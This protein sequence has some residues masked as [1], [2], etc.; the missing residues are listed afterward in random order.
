MY[1]QISPIFAPVIASDRKERSN[2]RARMLEMASDFALAMTG[3]N[4]REC[5]KSV[6]KSL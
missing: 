5:A 3:V 1:P 4:L 2:L 6:D